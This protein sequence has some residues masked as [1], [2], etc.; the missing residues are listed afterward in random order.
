MG[1]DTCAGGREDSVSAVCP[2]G[3]FISSSSTGSSHEGLSEL[4]CVCGVSLGVSMAQQVDRGTS[5]PSRQQKHGQ[6]VLVR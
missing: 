5:W 1:L 4:L 6:Y 3:G 2:L